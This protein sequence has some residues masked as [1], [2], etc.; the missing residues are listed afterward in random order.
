V[1]ACNRLP[2]YACSGAVFQTLLTHSEDIMNR[3]ILAG[4][5]GL[6]L[7]LSPRATAAGLSVGDVAPKLDLKEFVKGDVVKSF[8]KGKIYVVE[9]WATWC[10]PCRVSIPHLSELQKKYKDAIFIGV[11]VWEQ[12]QDKVKPFVDEM[13]DKM[14]YRVAIDDVGEGKGN[15]GKMAKQWMQAAEQDGIPAAFIVN[16]DGKIAWIGHPMNMDKPLEQIISGKWDL[17]KARADYQAEL[18]RKIKLRSIFGKLQVAMQAKDNKSIVA[19]V[20]EAIKEDANMEKTLGLFKFRA[21][22][23]QAD[24]DKT[25]QYGMHLA[26]GIY[27]DLPQ[28]LNE[29]AWTLVE[30][31]GEKADPKLMKFALGIAVKADKLAQGKD[32]GIADTLAKAYYETGDVATALSTQERAM[33]LS[34]GTPLEA[35]ATMKERLELYKKKASKPE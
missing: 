4:S 24:A 16:G 10:G 9:F 34:K 2:D 25:M 18:A 1:F 15:E 21:L 7:A 22:A 17:A 23:A 6:V 32:G 30:N 27:N 13:G 8:E 5:L 11:S 31:P 29:I 3:L 20:D 12:S 19:V 26:E 28:G 35:D 14:A 33:K